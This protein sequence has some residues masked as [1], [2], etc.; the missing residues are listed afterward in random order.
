[1]FLF[2]HQQQQWA[3]ASFFQFVTTVTTTT[4]NN[5][6]FENKILSIGKERGRWEYCFE[7]GSWVRRIGPWVK[8]NSLEGW[9]KKKSVTQPL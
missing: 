4:K 5:E 6:S 2:E 7:Q 8:K 3:M 1:L 9:P